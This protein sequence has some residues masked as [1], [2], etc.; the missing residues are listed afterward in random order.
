[1]KDITIFSTRSFGQDCLFNDDHLYT[2]LD[3]G[4][5]HYLNE[6]FGVEEISLRDSWWEALSRNDKLDAVKDIIANSISDENEKLRFE[7]EFEK[8][9][10]AED[11]ERYQSRNYIFDNYIENSPNGANAFLSHFVDLAHRNALDDPARLYRL[12]EGV[13]AVHL[14]EGN[15]EDKE[16]K[17]WIPT[18]LKCA[19]ALAQENAINVRLVLHDRDLGEKFV[20]DDVTCLDEDNTKKFAGEEMNGLASLSIVFF[21]HTSNAFALEI[22]GKPWTS[23]RLSIHEEVDKWINLYSTDLPKHLMAIDSAP[24]G[25]D[26]PLEVINAH[27]KEIISIKKGIA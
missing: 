23:N 9:E 19:K 1:M 10:N 3:D 26:S 22:L 17:L 12:C 8:G 5:K 20:E 27:Y 21:K 6:Y 15:H 16:G 2:T 25:M 4:I 13:Y 14:L 11:D 18:L 24:Y 7:F